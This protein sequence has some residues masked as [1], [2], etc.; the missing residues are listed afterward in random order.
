MNPFENFQ[1]LGKLSLTNED[2][3]FQ[4]E[5]NKKDVLE[6]N[7]ERPSFFL[8]YMIAVAVSFVFLF[9]L[10]DLQIVQAS[11]YQYMAE[12]NRI[13]TRDIVAPRGIIYDSSG[14][15]LAQNNASFNLEI[16]PADLPQNKIDRENVYSKIDEVSQISIDEIAKKIEAQGLFSIESVVLKE[17]IGRDEALLLKIKY[18][19]VLGVSVI[20][21]PTRQYQM[22]PG[23]SHFLGYIG[24]INDKELKDDPLYQ[25]NDYIGKTGLELTYENDLKGLNG[26]EQM[27]VDS[28]G[29]VQRQLASI[30]P[31]PGNNLYLGINLD[32]QKEMATNLSDMMSQS[33][34]GS[35]VAL[36]MNPQNGAILGMV[37]LPSYD[38]NLFSTGISSVNYQTLLSDPNKPLINRIISGLYPSGSTIKPFMA[39]AALQEG[40]ITK[41]TSIETPP[42]IT[43]SEWKFP[44]WKHHTGITNVTRAIAES[45]DIFFYA[46]S[47]GYDKIKG[48]GVEK[49]KKYLN[50]FGFGKPTGIDLDGEGSGL[51]P[52]PAWKKKVKNESWYLGDTYHLGIGQGDFLSTPLQLLNATSAIA[53]GGELLKPH[54]AVKETDITGKTVEEFGKEIIRSNFISQNNINIVREGMRGTVTGGSARSLG[55]L[56]VEVAAKTGTAQFGTGDATHSWLTAFA[57]YNN[58]QIAIVVLIEGG[59]EENSSTA[60]P[61]VK[62]ILQ[63]YFNH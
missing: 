47:G 19:D 2:Y 55:D 12:G 43:I 6:E 54:L 62:K 25:M 1:D 46:V 50:L 28:R 16:Y 40:T 34:V 14:Q 7:I 42:E 27:E 29:K 23:L 57:P 60:T 45:N 11:K 32:L 59:S 3:Q 26:K 17:N 48:L 24:K 56:P 44:D 5:E 35:G 63:W 9:K 33:K 8:I 37:S 20:S 52:D 10:I 30:D 36:A 22:V 4:G 39:A 15:V 41:N 49:A 58:P 21:R 31:K 53:N 18:Q 61:V 13:R 38:N 51:V